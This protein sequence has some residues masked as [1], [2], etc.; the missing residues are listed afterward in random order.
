MILEPEERIVFEGL[1]K[2]ISKRELSRICDCAPGTIEKIRLSLQ[3]KAAALD[4]V[5][6]VTGKQLLRSV[7]KGSRGDKSRSQ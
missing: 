6:T 2:E 4:P 5:G 7:K 3:A 1:G